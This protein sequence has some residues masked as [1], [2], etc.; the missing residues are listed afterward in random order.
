MTEQI[1]T[2]VNENIDDDI[3]DITLDELL[4]ADSNLQSQFDKK[5]ASAMAKNLEK[6]KAKWQAEADAKKAEAEKLAAMSEK[7]RN[8]TIMKKLESEKN[9]AYAKLAAYELRGEAEKIAK[10]KGL[11][12]AFL[13]YFDFGSETAETI[14]TKIDNISEFVATKIEQGI[15][16]KLRQASPKQ[17][18]GNQVSDEKA[19]LDAKY[20]NNP[21]YKK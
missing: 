9:S 19:Y 17:V 11:D 7:E 20:G 1:N 21:Y 15:N 18:F 13:D 16:D 2:D 5:I 6:E 3:Q 4:N 12:S 10:E 8:D 14:K